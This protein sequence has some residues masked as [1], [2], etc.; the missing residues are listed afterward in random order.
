MARARFRTACLV[1]IG[2]LAAALAFVG[3]R[4]EPPAVPPTPRVDEISPLGIRRG[5]GTQL[6]VRGEALLGNP[7]LVAPFRL[8]VAPPTPSASN[9]NTFETR[10]TVD[11]DTPLGIYPVRVLTDEGLSDPFPLAVGQVPQIQEKGDNP[12]PAR[13]LRDDDQSGPARPR[14]SR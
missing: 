1:G 7:R 6:T 8:V 10:L 13:P 11:P 4:P 12:D 5:Y 9:A 14:R 3:V 2:V